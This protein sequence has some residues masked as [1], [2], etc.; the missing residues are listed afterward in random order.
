[1]PSLLKCAEELTICFQRA[2]EN[3]DNIPIFFMDFETEEDHLYGEP[4]IL[5]DTDKDEIIWRNFNFYYPKGVSEL[6]YGIDVALENNIIRKSPFPQSIAYSFFKF[7]LRHLL[8]ILPMMHKNHTEKTN[9]EKSRSLGSVPLST[10]TSIREKAGL[11]QHS[12]RQKI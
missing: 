9:P 7:R 11:S 6:K 3:F 4:P 8:T 5:N 1:M 10:I 12:K 2:I